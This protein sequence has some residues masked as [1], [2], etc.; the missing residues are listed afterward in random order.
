MKYFKGKLFFLTIISLVII[1]CS[2]LPLGNT[3]KITK[4]ENNAD[5]GNLSVPTSE[6]QSSLAEKSTF[7]PKEISTMEASTIPVFSVGLNF[8]YD[9]GTNPPPGW[10]TYYCG[11]WI[12]SNVDRKFSDFLASEGEGIE[13]TRGKNLKAHDSN[14]K[15]IFVSTDA[16]VNYPVDIFLGTQLSSSPIEINLNTDDISIQ[17]GLPI[18]GKHREFGP[19]DERVL[20]EF[21]FVFTIPESMKPV[22]INLPVNKIKIVIPKL[23]SYIKTPDLK[24]DILTKLPSSIDSENVVSITLNEPTL[25]VADN[26]SGGASFLQFNLIAQ[27]KNT[28]KTSQQSGE[29]WQNNFNVYDPRGFYWKPENHISWNLAPLQSN[30]S[31]ET[32]IT[33]NSSLSDVLYLIPLDEKSN[34]AYKLETKS[35]KIANCVPATTEELSNSDNDMYPIFR[36]NRFNIIDD[37]IGPGEYDMNFTDRSRGLWTINLP[38]R[39]SVSLQLTGKSEMPGYIDKNYFSSVSIYLPDGTNIPIGQY[40]SSGT[41]FIGFFSLCE[42]YYL[43]MQNPTVIDFKQHIKIN[44]QIGNPQ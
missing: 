38:A 24:R 34:I 35:I 3:T 37:L 26:R 22:N 28:D 30:L 43:E 12:I 5:S 39:Q 2:M 9:E 7:S 19:S 20:S 31:S 36:D 18:V 16:D 11:F 1:S 8:C 40:E 44:T 21:L 32:Y 17:K 14:A 15:G 29:L 25:S 4:R 6:N 41:K 13:D 10:K 23:K 27:I 33:P 42:K